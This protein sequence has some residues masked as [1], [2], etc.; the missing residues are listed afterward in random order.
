MC[1]NKN[2]PANKTGGSRYFSTRDISGN[3][4]EV[5]KHFH[6]ADVILRVIVSRARSRAIEAKAGKQRIYLEKHEQYW[7]NNTLKS[8]NQNNSG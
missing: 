2:R 7:L 6:Q 5:E 3:T 1:L 8:F 4:V